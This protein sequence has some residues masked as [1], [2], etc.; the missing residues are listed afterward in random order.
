MSSA[1]AFPRI[2]LVDIGVEHDAKVNS[3]TKNTLRCKIPANIGRRTEIYVNFPLLE[4]AFSECLHIM[5][6]GGLVGCNVLVNLSISLTRSHS[7]TPD[8]WR[9]CMLR[10]EDWFEM[11]VDWFDWLII[12]SILR[13]KDTKTA[14]KFVFLLRTKGTWRH[15]FNV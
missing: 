3:D 7:P 8:V 10:M 11:I 15:S 4:S 9:D 13:W 14:T 12:R 1:I 5:L 2:I 6:W